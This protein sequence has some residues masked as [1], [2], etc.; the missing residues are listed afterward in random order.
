METRVAAVTV[1][2]AVPLMAPRVAVIVALP[3]VKVLARPPLLMVATLVA[4]EDQ[5]T[6]LV[7]F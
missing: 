4:L 2:L 5:V 7:R 3:T 1:R 6:A